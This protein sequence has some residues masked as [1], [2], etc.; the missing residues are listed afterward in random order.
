M[1]R[2]LSKEA[3]SLASCLKHRQPWKSSPVMNN[4]RATTKRG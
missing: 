1:R 2:P 3:T 4:G